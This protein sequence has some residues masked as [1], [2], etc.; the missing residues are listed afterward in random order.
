MAQRKTKE[1][2]KAIQRRLAVH[3]GTMGL[4]RKAHFESG[5]DLASWR[6]RA[7]VQTD[8]KKAANKKAC[9]KRVTFD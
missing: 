3:R 5:G 7:S 6:G 9:R 2:R 4:L 8:R 1:E